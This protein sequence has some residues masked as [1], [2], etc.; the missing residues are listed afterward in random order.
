MEVG[1]EREKNE[2]E[3]KKKKSPFAVHETNSIFAD[4]EL[5]RDDLLEPI[6]G[7]VTINTQTKVSARQQCEIQIYFQF[8]LLVFHFCIFFHFSFLFRTIFFHFSLCT[9]CVARAHLNDI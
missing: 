8:L 6:D 2:W 4:F 7:D 9:V 5:L 3:E 1:D